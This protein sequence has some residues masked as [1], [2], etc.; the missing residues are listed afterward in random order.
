ML[1][2]CPPNSLL[3]D[4]QQKVN[5]AQLAGQTVAVPTFT[6]VPG[7]DGTYSS[8]SAFSVEI[9]CETSGATIYYTTDGSTPTES[10]SAYTR[11]I[12]LVGNVATVVKA[13]G[14]RKP[15]TDSA[16]AQGTFTITYPTV[17]YDGNG[18]TG[19][20]APGTVA[21]QLGASVTVASG[22]SLAKTYYAF[23]GWNSARDGSGDSRDPGSLFAMGTSNIT[24]YAQWRLIQMVV[25][26][27]AAGDHFGQSLAIGNGDKT[28]L[29]G[30]PDKTISAVTKGAAYVFD[31]TGPAWSQSRLVAS[32]GAT[33]D[34][35]GYSGA[36]S[37][38]GNIAAIGAWSADSYRGAVYVFVRSGGIWS[39]DAKLSG[40]S[41]DYFGG[42]IALSGDGA[43]LAVGAY[44][45]DKVYVYTK[46]GTT[47]T[48]QTPPLSA[49]IAGDWFGYSV[50]LSDNGTTMVVGAP[51]CGAKGAAYVYGWLGS[52]WSTPQTLTASDGVNGDF[53]GQSVAIAS[54]SS[55]IAIGAP[56]RSTDTGACYLYTKPGSTWGILK[57]LT[58]G[59]SATNDHFSYSSTAFS[60]DGA[61][62]IVGAAG[63][64]IGTN[65]CQGAAYIFARASSW[66]QVQRL[67]IADGALNDYF[68]NSVAASVTGDK[69]FVGAYFRQIGSNANQG[70]AFVF[71]KSGSTW[72]Q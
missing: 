46:S 59:D 10:T 48:Q 71:T 40:A 34:E 20:T 38:D 55:S 56:F 72:S 9:A 39:Q 65:G 3:Q 24:L 50:A 69:V 37:N 66:N 6:P 58:A 28:V 43:T 27:G 63:K 52:S 14:V 67:T 1:V 41:G 31:N 25:D 53:F 36:M 15:M 64:Q 5:D 51:Q 29:V 11:P 26:D 70:T 18:N 49:G 21:Y 45:G 8:P 13:I 16:L 68:G 44:M 35:F 17:T 54:D 62:L 61:T 7:G 57:T 47:W 2:A 22:G 30:A 60:H 23:T 4:V 42:S 19:G 12:T 33:G 32:D